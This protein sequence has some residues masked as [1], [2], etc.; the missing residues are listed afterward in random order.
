[1]KKDNALSASVHRPLPTLHTTQYMPQYTTLRLRTLNAMCSW[2]VSLGDPGALPVLAGWGKSPRC[3]SVRVRGDVPQDREGMD[4]GEGG[5]CLPH[6]SSTAPRLPTNH[7]ELQKRNYTRTLCLWRLRDPWAREA[8]QR[9][10]RRA[11]SEAKRSE[12][13][14][15]G[16][17]E[18]SV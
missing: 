14:P 7:A 11:R 9:A 6:R 17:D 5:R 8:A 4:L 18:G 15:R 3:G 1:M 2:A 12:A 10:A 13:I 16:G